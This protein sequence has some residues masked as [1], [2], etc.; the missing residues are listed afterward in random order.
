MPKNSDFADPRKA[1]NLVRAAARETLSREQLD[2]GFHNAV[3]GGIFAAI[4]SC[5]H[6]PQKSFG[7]GG[8]AIGSTSAASNSTATLC[9]IS[10][11]VRT[12]RKPFALR[13][14]T[15]AKPISEPPLI[16]TL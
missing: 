4:L 15:P 3:L 1:S 5:W 2:G 13:T 7:T 12:T 6:F 10:S 9:W 16:R 14:S 11:T 8:A